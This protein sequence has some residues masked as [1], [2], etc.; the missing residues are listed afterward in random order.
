MPK[1]G[2]P[3][4]AKLKRWDA[5][6]RAAALRF[7]ALLLIAGSFLPLSA[8]VPQLLNYQGRVQVG[9]NDFNGTGHFK[10]ALVNSGGIATY[11]S[12]DGTPAGEPAAWAVRAEGRRVPAGA[13]GFTPSASGCR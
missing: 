7:T 13:G 2:Y 5:S 6:A 8:Q 10:F 1:L 4:A 12:N 3:A 11:W 9:T